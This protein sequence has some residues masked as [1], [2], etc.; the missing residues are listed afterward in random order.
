M[1]DNNTEAKNATSEKKN[2][3]ARIVEFIRQV[4][5]EL[6]K[7]HWPT[8]NELWTFFWVVIIFVLI[9]MVAIG[10]FDFIFAWLTNLIFA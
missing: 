7:V 4:I 6:S 5:S 3:F 10:I 1:A 8:R 2:I 9:I